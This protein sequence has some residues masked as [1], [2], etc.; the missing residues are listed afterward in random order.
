MPEQEMLGM[1]QEAGFLVGV[2]GRE[3]KSVAMIF[4]RPVSETN[5]LPELKKLIN[6]AFQQGRI[7]ERNT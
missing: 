1:I 4:A 7:H 5:C 6:L 3:P 2:L